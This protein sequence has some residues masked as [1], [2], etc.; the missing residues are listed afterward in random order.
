[1]TESP[2]AETAP[3][4]RL[5]GAGGVMGPVYPPDYSPGG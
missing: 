4:Q 2:G 1:M 3:P 5:G